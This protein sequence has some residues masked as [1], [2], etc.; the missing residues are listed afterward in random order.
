[1][2]TTSFLK[3]ILPSFGEF[4]DNWNDP[5][6]QN[7]E[8]IEDFSVE[9]YESLVGG[10]PATSTWASLRGSLSSLAERLAVGLNPDGTINLSGSPD[11]AALGSSPTNGDSTSGPRGRFDAS[12]F[13][14]WDAHSPVYGGRFLPEPNARG[15]L[16]VGMA[17]RTRDVGAGGAL[18][19]SS[20]PKTF[21]EG[22]VVGG[23]TP[24]VSAGPKAVTFSAT[25]GP[26]SAAW[27]SF[28]IDGYLFRIRQ[29]VLLDLTKDVN[30]VATGYGDI[31]ALFV[32]RGDYNNLNTGLKLP[33]DGGGAAP[34]DL[35]RLQS[36]SAGAI[37][38]KNFV[39]ASAAFTG[40]S[41]KWT[42]LPGDV[43][44]VTTG[45]AA[46]RYVI[47]SV[48]SATSV[49]IAGTF[50][51]D[52][53]AGLSWYIEDI[54]HP[55]LGCI[56]L[57]DSS[58]EPPY[59]P[60]R[61]YIGRGAIDAGGF[62]PVGSGGRIAFPSN[63]IYDTG[64]LNQAVADFPLSI[65]H[66]LGVSPSQ[67]QIFVRAS[68]AGDTYEPMV[69]RS[70]V[71]TAVDAGGADGVV[72][73][74]EITKTAKFRVPSMYWHTSRQNL[75]LRLIEDTDLPKALFTDKDSGAVTSGQVRVIVRR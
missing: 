35:R 29:S 3:L 59:E 66:N 56:K 14:V 53:L 75:M 15:S 38:G 63:G 9:L 40:S 1:M 18:G 36:G 25:L 69:E 43:L 20:P 52:A 55:N 31:V 45:A 44:V 60:G 65:E 19:I 26:S 64:W 37:S 16:D 42:V 6:N 73:Y 13:E 46:G 68:S 72:N 71:L 34:K 8:N 41:S 10:S 48:A 49:A 17:H 7:F 21:V 5:L 12:D 32:A 51:A 22:L 2:S 62:K 23:V 70:V 67:V 11:I 61:V 30:G 58:S 54:H 33:G 4:R 74:S 50:K 47:A 27:L 24:L 57:T 28:N 39:D